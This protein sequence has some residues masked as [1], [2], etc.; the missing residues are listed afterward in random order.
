MGSV[1]RQTSHIGNLITHD[2]R[3]MLLS[4]R[5]VRKKVFD[6]YFAP[7]VGTGLSFVGRLDLT[8]KTAY[9]DSGISNLT[10]SDRPIH[11]DVPFLRNLSKGSAKNRIWTTNGF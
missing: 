9:V 10:A 1:S 5:K 3:G 8:I 7:L 2:E 11:N 4:P 6:T